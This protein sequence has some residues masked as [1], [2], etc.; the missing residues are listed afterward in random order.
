[1]LRQCDEKPYLAQVWGRFTQLSH[2]L[3]H[4]FCGQAKRGI[5][6]QRLGPRFLHDASRKRRKLLSLKQFS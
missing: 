2:K 3:I 1:M 6:S 5:P 4:R